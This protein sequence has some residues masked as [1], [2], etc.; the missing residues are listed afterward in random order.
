M[1]TSPRLKNQSDTENDSS[2]SR[3]AL[4]T[5]SGRRQSTRPSRK[6]AQNESQTQVL[7]IFAPPNAP[8]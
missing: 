5:E 8:L 7:L 2:T 4:R 1:K 3:S 6:S